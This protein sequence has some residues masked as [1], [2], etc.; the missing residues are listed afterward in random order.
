MVRVNVLALVA[1]PVARRG[2]KAT[3]LS[4]DSRVAIRALNVLGV[5]SAQPGPVTGHRFF[6]DHFPAAKRGTREIIAE[7]DGT[8]MVAKGYR[9][10]VGE[11]DQNQEFAR[12]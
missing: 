4:R 1:K 12:M 5:K 7:R 11:T 2:R 10:H 6:C 3:G 8:F 9:R